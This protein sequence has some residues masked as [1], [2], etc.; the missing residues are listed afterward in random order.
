[1]EQ[2]IERLRRELPTVF[3]GA[4]V[5]ELTGGAISWGTTQNRRSRGEIPNE[6][7]MFIRSGNRVLVSAI[8]SWSGGQ[9]P[10]RMPG[11]LPSHHRRTEDGVGMAPKRTRAPRRSNRRGRRQPRRGWY[12][13]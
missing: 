8:H 11:A 9:P 5:A 2:L 13:G 7:E 1:M 3:L 12:R 10:C 4:K 6:D